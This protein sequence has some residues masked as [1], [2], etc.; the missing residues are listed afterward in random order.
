MSIK[1]LKSLLSKIEEN[2][3]SNELDM[4]MYSNE[5]YH[6][7]PDCKT[8]CCVAGWSARWGVGEFEKFIREEGFSYRSY[9]NAELL[10]TDSERHGL[11]VNNARDFMFGTRWGNDWNEAIARIK[12]VVAQDYHK[13]K[14]DGFNN[15]SYTKSYV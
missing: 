12:I 6:Q 7:E 5:N 1:N 2:R 10:P 14:L 9:I 11:S 15:I 3:F 13:I 8:T 4:F